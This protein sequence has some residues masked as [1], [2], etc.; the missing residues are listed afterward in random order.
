MKPEKIILFGSFARGDI[1]ESS[2]VDLIVVSNWRED[3]IKRIKMLLDMN[4]FRIPLEPVGYTR[5]EFENL[6]KE[7]NSFILEVL[8]EGR[9]LYKR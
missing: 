4:E 1:S 5:E 9:I 2:D 6:V 7:R 3:F 8:K